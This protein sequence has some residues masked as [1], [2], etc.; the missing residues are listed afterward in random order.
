MLIK[1]AFFLIIIV[2][3]MAGCSAGNMVTVKIQ[4][5]T[6]A[7]DAST[8]AS[9]T[10]SGSIKT[11]STSTAPVVTAGNTNINTSAS[12]GTKTVKEIAIPA[13]LQWP[14]L[15]ASQAP[16]T[17]WDALHEEACEEASMIMAVKYFRKLP[18]DNNIMEEEIQ[19]LVKWET[20]NGYSVDLNAA[21]IAQVMADYFNFNV[22]ISREVNADQMKYELAKGNL[23]IVPAAGRD[24]HNPNFKAP[25]PVYHMLVIKGYNSRQFITNDPGTRKGN[26]YLY[27][28]ATLISAIHDWNPDLA[29]G[30]M[31]TEEMRL[32]EKL[33]IIVSRP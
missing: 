4:E 25:G 31:T 7:I 16:L 26:G 3:L 27:D 33:I 30:E 15:F 10:G 13:Q 9:T 14:V 22:R 32:G 11:D 8:T 20:D 29:K 12:T 28:Y 19:R 23:I 21:E 1:R 24:L 5:E 18:L 17:N 2:L 6:P